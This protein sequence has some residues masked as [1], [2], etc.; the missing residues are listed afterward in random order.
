MIR[1][2]PAD[3]S[4]DMSEEKRFYYLR[5][6]AK[7]GGKPIKTKF[8]TWAPEDEA[9]PSELVGFRDDPQLEV[10]KYKRHSSQLNGGKIL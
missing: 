4:S 2:D 6:M 1:L 7:P 8:A 10:Q 9:G 3:E 5:L